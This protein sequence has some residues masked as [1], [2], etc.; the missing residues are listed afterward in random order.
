MRK[1]PTHGENQGVNAPDG[2]R[3]D[4]PDGPDSSRL[5]HLTSFAPPPGRRSFGLLGRK[6]KRGFDEY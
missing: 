4:P 5:N 2:G 6:T 3:Q 1:P